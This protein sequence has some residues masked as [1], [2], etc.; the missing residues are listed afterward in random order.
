[1]L[2][3]PVSLLHD[4]TNAKAE[5]AEYLILMSLVGIAVHGMDPLAAVVVPTNLPAAIL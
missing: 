2:M 4:K 5:L 3:A 1:M